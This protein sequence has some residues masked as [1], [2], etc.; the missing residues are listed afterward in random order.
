MLID[1]FNIC[2]QY[3]QGFLNTGEATPLATDGWNM[4][5]DIVSA[6]STSMVQ[7]SALTT[8][9]IPVIHCALIRFRNKLGFASGGF[10]RVYFG[11]YKGQKVA[12]K[13]V[14]GLMAVGCRHFLTCIASVVC[15]GAD[16]FQY[17]GVL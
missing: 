4:N 12:V 9:H 6:L 13:M 3:W 2:F 8:E 1:N 15:D 7:P 10:S 14:S 11:E 17:R 5:L 16:T